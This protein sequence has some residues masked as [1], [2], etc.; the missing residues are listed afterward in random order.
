MSGAENGGGAAPVGSGRHI[1]RA[2][3]DIGSIAHRN[4]FFWE[5][6]W[7]HP[8]NA[9]LRRVRKNPNVLRPGDRIAIPERRV[10]YRSA[11]TEQKHRFRV[12]GVPAKIRLQ[13]LEA[14][15]PRA[16]TEYVFN[17]DGVDREGRTDGEGW[18]ELSIPPDAQRG[19]IYLDGDPDPTYELDLGGARSD[20]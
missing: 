6:V 3:Q 12:K 1:V 19:L 5:T 8:D 15:T 20:R 17:L 18:I 16:D 2:G 14:D 9:E 4:G 10:E 11:A 13:V 7:Q